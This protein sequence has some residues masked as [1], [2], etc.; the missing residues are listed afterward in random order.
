MRAIGYCLALVVLSGCAAGATPPAEPEVADDDASPSG[1]C[2]PAPDVLRQ[3][4]DTYHEALVWH[5][6]VPEG[7]YE[8]LLTVSPGGET[9]T[10]MILRP[11]GMV[12]P[13]AAGTKSRMKPPGAPA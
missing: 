2:A 8:A 5:G 7:S 12:C 6:A 1:H 4:A 3:L 13:L 11:D 10:F 9:W